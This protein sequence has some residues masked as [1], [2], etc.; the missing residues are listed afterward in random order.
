MYVGQTTRSFAACRRQ[1]SS[2]NACNPD[3]GAPHSRSLLAAGCFVR[4]STFRPRSTFTRS[5]SPTA[6]SKPPRIASRSISNSPAMVL[7][8]TYRSRCNTTSS[9]VRFVH[10]A[11]IHVDRCIAGSMMLM[12]LGNCSLSV[13]L[14]SAPAPPAPPGTITVTFTITEPNNY[15]VHISLRKKPICFSPYYLTVLSGTPNCILLRN[16]LVLSR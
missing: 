10:V 8:S 3:H 2:A 7:V 6:T 12:V 15:L 4:C 9:K 5:P 11:R 1:L 14:C 13:V 16:S